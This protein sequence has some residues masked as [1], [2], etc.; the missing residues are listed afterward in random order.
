L[1]H[2]NDLAPLAQLGDPAARDALCRMG[3]RLVG[4]RIAKHVRFLPPA[5]GNWNDL[6]QEGMIGLLEALD[7]WKPEAMGFTSFAC[8]C[9]DRQLDQAVRMAT[10]RKHEPLNRAARLEKPIPHTDNGRGA[11]KTLLDF[12]HLPATDEA[13]RDPLAALLAAAERSEARQLIAEFRATI[14]PPLER[15]TFDQCVVLLRSYKTVA[16]ELGVHWKSVD[17]ASQRVM[18]K[19]RRRALELS[20]DERYSPDLRAMLRRCGRPGRRRCGRPAVTEWI[21]D[22]MQ[23]GA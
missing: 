15:H 22:L 9:I 7:D 21:G 12:L 18:K 23:E 4:S 17:N 20:A 16:A 5:W 3:Y 13:G 14:R 11:N 1:P 6:L 2:L 8:I 10:R 19:I